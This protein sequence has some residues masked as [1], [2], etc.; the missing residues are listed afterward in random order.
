MKC[1]NELKHFYFSPEQKHN[2]VDNDYQLT[3]CLRRKVWDK[4]KKTHDQLRNSFGRFFCNVITDSHEQI[5][6]KL[7][8]ISLAST[9]TI[10]Q[11]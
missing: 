9:L 5:P 11:W 4:S 2:S 7:N 10:G 8:R 6:M 3:A 1:M